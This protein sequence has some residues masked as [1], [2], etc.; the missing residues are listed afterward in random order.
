MELSEICELIVD[1]EHKTAPAQDIGYP[2]IR[3][4]NIGPGYF[5]LDGVNRV[6]KETYELWTKR[7]VPQYGDI[8]MARE[9]PVGNAAI[10]RGEL[11]PCLGQRTLLIRPNKKKA[12]PLFLNYYLNGPHIQGVI[13]SKTNGATVAHLNMKDVRSL[14][15]TTLPLIE[16]QRRIAGVLSAYDELIENN[17]RRIRILEEMARSLYREWFVHFRFPGHENHPCV[18]SPLGEIPEG[19]E[20]KPL[21]AICAKITDGAH[22][23]PPS[24]S[25]GYPMA[26][27]KDMHTWGIHLD[28]CRKISEDDYRALVRNGCK[29]EKDDIL[30]AKDGSYLKHIFVVEKDLDLVI[31]S[32]IAL[33]RPASSIEPTYMSFVLNQPET[34]ARMT[35][36]VSGVA[37]PRI[38][39]K[40]FRRFQIVVPP[41]NVQGFWAKEAVP[42]VKMC[43]TLVAQSNNLRITRDLLL[44]RLLSGKIKLEGD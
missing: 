13:H 5:I 7:A 42:M 19:W 23:S 36:F 31:L 10:I 9:A 3:T 39:L 8:I 35:G 30:V 41:E 32:S 43:Q 4:P 40:D 29:P 11:R 12:D 18:P 26:S 22:H 6:S 24:V 1:C 16:K 17:Q 14:P 15:L 34:I 2:S 20:V 38:V 44:P 37:I 28:T 33:L 27:V 21:E 25:V